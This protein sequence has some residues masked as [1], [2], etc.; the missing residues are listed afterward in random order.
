MLRNENKK[1]LTI[2]ETRKCY[3][4]CPREKQ[5][6]DNARE[7][8]S[9]EDVDKFYRFL[10]GEVPEE[11]TLKRPLKLSSRQAFLV[12][13]YLQEVFGILPDNYERCKTCGDLFDSDYAVGK[14]DHCYNHDYLD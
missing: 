10:Q 14:K 5:F 2:D 6:I 9:I 13:Y 8:I 1:M 12:I 3:D 7:E 4:C 11:L